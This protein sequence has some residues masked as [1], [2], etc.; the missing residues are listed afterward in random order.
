VFEDRVLSKLFGTERDEVRGEWRRLHNE[1]LYDAYCS[2]NIKSRTIEWMGHIA[3]TRREYTR[4][5]WGYLRGKS[6]SEKSR[7]R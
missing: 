2:P 1:E 3:R 6:R 7:C 5:L 4:F